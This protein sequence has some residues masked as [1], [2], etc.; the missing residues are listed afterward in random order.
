MSIDTG[1]KNAISIYKTNALFLPIKSKLQHSQTG[2]LYQSG[3]RKKNE[4]VIT[5]HLQDSTNYVLGSS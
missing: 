2:C 5:L 3:V 4:A 1:F